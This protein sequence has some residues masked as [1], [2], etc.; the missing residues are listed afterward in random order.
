VFADYAYNLKLI[1]DH[2]IFE[3]IGDVITLYNVNGFSAVA[4]DPQFEKDKKK[5]V[6]SALGHL[7]YYWGVTYRFLLTIKKY[8]FKH[9]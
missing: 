2:I 7:P 8:I 3:Y 9:D 4:K 1:E 6:L 5:L